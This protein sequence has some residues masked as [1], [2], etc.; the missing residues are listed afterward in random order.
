MRELCKAPRKGSEKDVKSPAVNLSPV[1][2]EVWIVTDSERMPW[3]TGRNPPRLPP[4]GGVGG[5]HAPLRLGGVQWG[6]GE[7]LPL[8]ACACVEDIVWVLRS[9]GP[10]VECVASY[11]GTFRTVWPLVGDTGR[12]RRAVKW[13]VQKVWV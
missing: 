8:T 1:S 5:L 10:L 11:E 6:A 4:T 3:S 9:L 2:V 13:G 12:R 7:R